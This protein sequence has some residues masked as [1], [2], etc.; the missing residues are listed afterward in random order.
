MIPETG[1]SWSDIKNFVGLMAVNYGAEAVGALATTALTKNPEA[2]LGT[3]TGIRAAAAGT[4]L[5]LTAA[6]RRH[7]TNSEAMDA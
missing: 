2:A 6:M 5:G 3:L 4:T 7:E 1:S